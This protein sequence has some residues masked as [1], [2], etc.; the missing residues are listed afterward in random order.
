LLLELSLGLEDGR[1]RALEALQLITTHFPTVQARIN[2]CEAL[3]VLCRA[4][5]LPYQAAGGLLA[6]SR[7]AGCVA[8][9]FEQRAQN[10]VIR[11]RGKFVTPSIGRR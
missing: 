6:F 11:P 9:V 5:G 1:D 10:L 8:H 2:L 7:T 4:L 3:V